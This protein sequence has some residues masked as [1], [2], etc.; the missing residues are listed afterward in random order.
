MLAVGLTSAPAAADKETRQM[1]A[2]IRMLQEQAQQ[3]QNL[4]T[5]LNETLN[6]TINETVANAVKAVNTRV[7]AKV[8]E[9]AGAS[10]KAFADQNVVI[11]AMS[12]DLRTLKEKADDTSGRLGGLRQDIDALRAIVTQLQ[13]A[14]T[15]YDPVLGPP[16][17]APP[18]PAAATLGMSPGEL[19]EIGYG[20]YA[21]GQY[22]S[23]ISALKTYVS[24]FPKSE[25]AEDAQLTICSA[26]L[27]IPK[28]KE[29]VEACDASIRMYPG[30]KR[31]AEA[32]FRKAEALQNLKQVA[33]AREAYETILKLF[34][35]S[36]AALQARQRLQE[37]KR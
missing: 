34:P 21:A 37:L 27:R 5:T 1:M 8:D 22:D 15:T 14:R 6:K 30:G 35:D 13:T 36:D 33:P 19:F 16:D 32:Y 25:K 10:R 26:Y 12:A 2:D 28:Y 24:T 29:A 17:G 31:L 3:L 18:P 23:A 20:D 4:I 9:Q 7:D 11:G